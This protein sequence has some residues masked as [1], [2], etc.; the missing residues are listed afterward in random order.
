MRSKL[1][2][3][4]KSIDCYNVLTQRAR[5]VVVEKGKQISKGILKGS[6]ESKNSRPVKK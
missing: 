3:G 1:S 2:F 4:S 5:K 6:N